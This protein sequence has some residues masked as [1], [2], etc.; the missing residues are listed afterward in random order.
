[1]PQTPARGK[2]DRQAQGRRVAPA[3]RSAVE[4]LCGQSLSRAAP[5]DA[6]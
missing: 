5:P 1:M 3:V 4:T 2:Q 6:D